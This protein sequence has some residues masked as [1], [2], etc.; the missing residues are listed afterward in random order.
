M[1][2]KKKEKNVFKLDSTVLCMHITANMARLNN[3]K[4]FVYIIITI[5][6][7]VLQLHL[8]S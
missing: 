7:C 2:F 6:N 1:D 8:Q 4:K 3:F 5:I